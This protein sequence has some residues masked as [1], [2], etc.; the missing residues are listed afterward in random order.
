[1][2]RNLYFG[3]IKLIDA[4]FIKYSKR[5]KRLI[6]NLYISIPGTKPNLILAK[7]SG[8]L[9]YSA[10]ILS[11]WIIF[12]KSY[13]IRNKNPSRKKPEI[14]E[15]SYSFKNSTVNRRRSWKYN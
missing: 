5:R 2:S 11:E 3:I 7:L 10:D 8:Q 13:F 4:L 14:C 9:V 12:Y 1:M 6:N 15:I